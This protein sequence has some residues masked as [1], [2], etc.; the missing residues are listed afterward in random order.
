MRRKL[1]VR[2][3]SSRFVVSICEVPQAMFL[4]LRHGDGHTQGSGESQRFQRMP[5][6]IEALQIVSLLALSSIVFSLGPGK[7]N[8]G[9]SRI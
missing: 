3:A 7:S 9:L 4:E 6:Q 2:G 8:V 1:T 5:N